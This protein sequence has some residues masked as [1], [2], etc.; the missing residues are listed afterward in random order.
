MNL[1]ERLQ[2]IRQEK[3]WTLQEFAKRSGVGINTLSRLERGIGK[4]TFKTHQKICDALDINIVDLYKDV[5]THEEDVSAG[6]PESQEIET[7]LYNDKASSVILTHNAL[8]KNMLPAL[9]MLEP[10]GQTHKEQNPKGTEKFLFCLEGSLEV[11]I[12]EKALM[13][14]PN[15]V[16]YFKSSLFHQ[17][18]N[19]GSTKARCLCISSPAAI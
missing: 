8:R 5:E 13:L 4:G 15:G 12:G 14:G 11:T 2:K 9:L 16:L 19:T 10:K 7:F 3:G 18:K 6:T 1:K 17:I